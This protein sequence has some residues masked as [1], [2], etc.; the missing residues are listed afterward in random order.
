MVYT[1]LSETQET[2]SGLGRL[3]V[4]VSR[5]HTLRHFPVDEW[6]GRR[7][8][9]Y[10]GNTT[11][12][13]D[14]TSIPSAAF[15]PESQQSSDRRPTLRPHGHWDWP[16]ETS[17]VYILETRQLRI[18]ENVIKFSALE[19]RTADKSRHA[20]RRIYSRPVR[21][22]S[23]AVFLIKRRTPDLV[24]IFHIALILSHAIVSNSFIMQPFQ[25]CY[26]IWICIYKRIKSNVVLLH[27]QKHTVES[28]TLLRR[29][30]VHNV[31]SHTVLRHGQKH[32]VESHTLLRREDVHIVESHSVLRHGQKHIVESH[33][34]LQRGK[35]HIV[36][37]HTVLRH[38]QT[39]VVETHKLL[40]R[41]QTHRLQ[42][43]T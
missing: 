9:R 2:N 1:F 5:S 12:T 42:A 21:S 32:I 40:R 34:L 7:R 22:R 15:E 37:G 29:G 8:R 11:N 14:H 31:E 38:G 39:H 24:L 25:T 33:T 41:G 13:R 18:Q 4:K 3:D 26:K 43:I 10:L 35:V 27:A 16:K 30:K 36:E 19:D 17:H 28:Y 23:T 6:L 20:A